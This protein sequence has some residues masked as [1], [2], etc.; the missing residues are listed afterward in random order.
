MSEPRI[1]TETIE[2]A[3][4]PYL[5]LIEGKVPA[6]ATTTVYHRGFRAGLVDVIS[7][8]RTFA[9]ATLPRTEP[10]WV[11]RD[12]IE[13]GVDLLKRWKTH[14]P[15]TAGY[16]DAFDVVTRAVLRAC[17]IEANSPHIENP[18]PTEQIA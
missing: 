7:Q 11:R 12:T 17:G 4:S 5:P 9:Y 15:R 18:E 6:R 3:L 2:N 16:L 13:L 1:E 14:D 10:K 8:W